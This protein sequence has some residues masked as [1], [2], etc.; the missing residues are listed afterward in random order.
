MTNLTLKVKVKV[1]SFKL[2]QTFRLSMN[3]F[4]V[5]AK[6][7]NSQFKSSKLIFCKFKGQSELQGK[8][9]GL[10]FFKIIRPLDDQYTSQV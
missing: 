6:L 8:C 4:C 3:S 9:Q 1:P 2:V 10:H 7:Q 5:N